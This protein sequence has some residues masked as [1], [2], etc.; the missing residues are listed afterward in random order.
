MRITCIRDQRKRTTT[1][2]AT[3]MNNLLMRS[4]FLS[5]SIRYSPPSESIEFFMRQNE[6]FARHFYQ[7]KVRRALHT[8]P[9]RNHNS[10]KKFGRK[11]SLHSEA[12]HISESNV[13]LHSLAC[14]MHERASATHEYQSTFLFVLSF[15]PLTLLFRSIRIEMFRSET[16]EMRGAKNE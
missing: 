2:A 9:Q 6:F 14:P 16:N 5:P 11:G 7:Y 3:L 1:T 8:L 12:V 4:T 15:G 10:R 13:H